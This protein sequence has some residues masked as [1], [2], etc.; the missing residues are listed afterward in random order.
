MID[1][2]TNAFIDWC[3]RDTAAARLQ[4]TVVQGIIAVIVGLI[5]MWSDAPEWATVAAMPLVM[6][7]LSPIQAAIGNSGEVGPRKEGSD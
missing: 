2:A 4:R 7:V 1:K 6:A 3:A 5:T